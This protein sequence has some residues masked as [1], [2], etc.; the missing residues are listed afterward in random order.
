MQ[1]TDDEVTMN[2]ILFTVGAGAALMLGLTAC[3]PPAAEQPVAPPVE[4]SDFD[5]LVADAQAEGSLRVYAQ[6]PEASMTK[7]VEVF[8]EKYGIK[9]EALRLGGNTLSSR[10]D[11]EVTA[12]TATGEALIVV[13]VEYL[14]KA[15]A[16][17]H[18]RGFSETGVVDYLEGFPE[19]AIFTEFDAP[20]VQVLDTGFI[21]NTAD[22][23]ASE[24]PTA[25]TGL[26][27]SRWQGKTCAVDPATSVNVAHFFWKL[28][29][30]MGDDALAT[31]GGNIG[32]WYPNV[33]AMNEAVA[34]GE[35]ELG[36]NSAKFFV[37]QGKGAGAPIEFAS[38]PDAIPPLVSAG[39]A[40]NAEHP[41]AALLFTH[42]ILSEE[43]NALLND[44]AIG[45]IGPWNMDALGDN[46]M[47][48]TAAEFEEVRAATPDVLKA[49][50]L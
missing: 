30:E 32:R 37:E 23:K 12:G 8:Q 27:D 39:V 19:E 22:V 20:N 45:A 10:F 3:A 47:V 26:N 13:D 6:I 35:C 7:F 5:T 31:L 50:G 34:V 9:V 16:D 11:S 44:P 18:I 24:V 14:A 1:F 2:K 29:Q 36:L 17:G 49:L 21:F 40:T 33:I 38:A 41:N 46:F 42:F 28:G 43:G 25:W 15:T 48:P 4:I